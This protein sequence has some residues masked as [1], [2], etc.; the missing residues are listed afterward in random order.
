MDSSTVEPS[1]PFLSKLSEAEGRA[2]SLEQVAQSLGSLD[3][4]PLT[5]DSLLSLWPCSVWREKEEMVPSLRIHWASKPNYN[6]HVIGLPQGSTPG[7]IRVY[8][9]LWEYKGME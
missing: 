7:P 5:P 2:G 3:A 4:L 9:G 8:V 6:A 1:L